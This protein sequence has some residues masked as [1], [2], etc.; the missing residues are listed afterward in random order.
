M[1]CNTQTLSSY[2]ATADMQD[3]QGNVGIHIPLQVTVLFKPEF[4]ICKLSLYVIHCHFNQRW[5]IVQIR[6]TEID[7]SKNNTVCR[8]SS[9]KHFQTWLNLGSVNVVYCLGRAYC[10]IGC[11]WK[12]VESKKQI[13]KHHFFTGNSINSG[14]KCLAKILH[15][16]LI[17]YPTVQRAIQKASAAICIEPYS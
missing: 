2:S 5:Y 13:P 4:S 7:S 16:S 1:I 3:L 12:F 11:C 8:N 17:T 9:R 10:W 15:I 6:C 14:T